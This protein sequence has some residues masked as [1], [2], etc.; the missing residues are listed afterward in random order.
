MFQVSTASSQLSKPAQYEEL[1][2]QARSLLAD[3]TDRIANAANFSSLVFN[4]L[5]G[6]NWAGF[7]FFDGVELLSVLTRD[8]QERG[9]D[10][11]FLMATAFADVMP[12][13]LSRMRKP[14]E[15]SDKW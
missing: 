15:G 2:A 14:W 1:V 3:E 12:V 8:A 9:V 7:Y 11:L 10:A 13:G 6:L 4:S 5:E